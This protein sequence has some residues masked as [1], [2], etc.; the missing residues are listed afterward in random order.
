MAKL[1]DKLWNWG[2]LEGNHNRITNF[3]CSMTPEEFAE[4]YGIKNS[5]IVSYGGDIN[6]PFNNYAKRFSGLNNVIWSVLGDGSTPLPDDE[7]GNTNDIIDVL[8]DGKNIIGGVVDDFF[9]PNRMERFTPQILKKIRAKLNENGLKFWCVLYASQLNLDLEKY[10]DCFDGVTFW[11]WECDHIVNQE[12]YTEKLKSIFGNT[13]M[14]YGVYLWNYNS[15]K[16][17]DTELF[18]SQ[19]EYCTKLLKAKEIEGII[20]CSNT[21][22]DAPLETNKLLKEFVKEKGNMEI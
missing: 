1:K 15:V 22:G 8:K 11:I 5:F 10:V 19:L 3:D 9:S 2:H 17:M 4:E 18:K 7:L 6:P 13:P 21:I 16:P 14:M 20:F 12:K